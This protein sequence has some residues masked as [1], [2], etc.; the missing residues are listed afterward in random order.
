MATPVLSSCV[1]HQP[2]AVVMDVFSYLSPK[3][4]LRAG[5]VCREF[6]GR[7]E[8]PSLWTHLFLTD[9]EPRGDEAQ[10]IATRLTSPKE[11]YRRRWGPVC[12]RAARSAVYLFVIVA[13]PP[14]PTPPHLHPFTTV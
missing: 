2:A 3:D 6:R 13:P 8:E 10:H 14:P 1:V 11:M 4:I 5:A 9:F 12:V 7:A